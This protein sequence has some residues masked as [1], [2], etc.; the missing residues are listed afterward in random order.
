[1][2]VLLVPAVRKTD[3]PRLK[4]QPEEIGSDPRV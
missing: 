3:L 2:A 1:L 4:P